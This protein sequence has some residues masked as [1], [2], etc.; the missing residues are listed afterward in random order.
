MEAAQLTQQLG[1]WTQTPGPLYRRLAT[2]FQ[3]AVEQGL[4]APGA[5]VPPEREL[6]KALALSRTT[7]L[8]AYNTL[9]ADGWLESKTGSGTWVSHRLASAARHRTHAATVNGA[10]TVSLLQIG[11]E[12]VDLAMGTLFPLAELPAELLAI[13]AAS[14][15]ALLTERSYMP[16]GL[17]RLRAAIA[18]LYTSHGLPT[19]TEQILVTSGAQ[20]ALSLITALC[21]Q[22]GDAV[23]VENPTYF[24]ALDAF[25]LAGARLSPVPVGPEHVR[26]SMLRDRLLS[27]GHRLM[28]LTPTWQN[29][30]GV[31]MPESARQSV[32]ALADEFGIPVVEDHTMSDLSIEGTPPG[33]IARYSKAGMVLTVGSLSKIFWAALRVGWIR[34]PVGTIARLARIKT[35]SDLGSALL[36]QAIGAQL[37]T[38]LDR[39]KQMRR[40]EL[41]RKRDLVASLLRE[42]LPEWDFSIPRG[43]V[44]L[45][46]KLPG[47]DARY[48]VQCAARHGVAV[49]AGSIFAA[50]ESFPDYLRIPYVLDEP[51]LALGVD[52]LASAWT[53]YRGSTEARTARSEPIV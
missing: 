29:P 8:T 46:V 14:Q 15:R 45:W 36:T 35:G 19:D 27:V 2:A 39:A 40:H 33:F 34:G 31:V 30:T 25:R 16:L 26:S 50:D 23:L 52:R 44:S 38:V 4:I 12:A 9:R 1:N 20:Q 24:G 18:R 21:I 41:A 53:E 13:D 43:G 37:L 51:S 28:Y 48:F 10:S 22:R 6:A 32:A 7:V 11:G 42:K 47:C 5:R 49:S 3:Q 17:P